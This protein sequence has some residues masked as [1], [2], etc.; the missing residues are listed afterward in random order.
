M[1][2]RRQDGGSPY[3][4]RCG[5]RMNCRQTTMRNCGIPWSG[6]ELLRCARPAPGLGGNTHGAAEGVG[7]ITGVAETGQVWRAAILA[8]TRLPTSRG[9]AR[10]PAEPSDD[11]KQLFENNS[12]LA[13]GLTRPRPFADPQTVTILNVQGASAGQCCS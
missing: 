7:K 2:E 9:G 8:A 3:G 1:Y 13:R 4:G 5:R 10:R 6:G 12:P 11:W